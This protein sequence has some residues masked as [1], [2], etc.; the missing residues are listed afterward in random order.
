[1]NTFQSGHIRIWLIL[2]LSLS[3][4][5]QEGRGQATLTIS[6]DPT[7]S[8]WSYASGILT[9]NLTSTANVNDIIGYL[10]AGPL[11]IVGA[12]PDLSVTV[13]SAIS[14]TGTANGL[15]IG[16]DGNTGYI[17]LDGLLTLKG[18]VTLI[19]DNIDVNQNLNTQAGGAN[20]DLL[21]KASGDIV[22]KGGIS[23][24]TNGGDAIFWA[25]SDGQSS[26]GGVI[27]KSGSAV[28]TG[29]GHIWIGG[30]NSTATWQGLTVGNGA[31]VSGRLTDDGVYFPYSGLATDNWQA[32][33]IFNMATLSSAGG[34]IQVTGACNITPPVSSR[35]AG[36]I[37]YSGNSGTLIDAGL[38]TVQLIGNNNREG[39]GIITGLHPS[40]YT[41]KFIVKSSNSTSANAIMLEGNAN[42]W[43]GVDG[44]LI[45]DHTRL[46]SSATTSGGGISIIGSAGFG[47]NG[48]MVGSN[49]LCEV[50]SA[51]G[52]ITVNAGTISALGVDGTAFFNI[53]SVSG[54][55]DV[56]ASTASVDI[57]YDNNSTTG[58]IPIRTSG[59]CIIKHNS[60]PGFGPRIITTPYSFQGVSAL[61][62]GDASDPLNAAV[63]IDVPLSIA[64]PITVYGGHHV[65]VSE[66]ITSTTGADISLYALYQFG[67]P[68]SSKRKRI[69]TSGGDITIN[70]DLDANGDPGGN[71]A[72]YLNDLTLDAGAGDIKVTGAT[73]GWLATDPLPYING[74]GTFTLESGDGDFK[75]M[76]NT[77]MFQFDQDGNGMGG[78]TIGKTTN[79]SPVIHD[80]PGGITAAGP[81]KIYAGG[82]DLNTPLTATGASGT[83]DIIATAG[84]TMNVP[85]IAS[86]NK[87]IEVQN[88][89]KIMGEITN[90]TLTG[91]VDPQLI[92]GT[93][94]ITNFTVNKPLNYLS[95]MS[96]VGLIDMKTVTGVLTITSGKLGVGGSY[97]SIPGNLKLKSD[98]NGT[99]RVAAHTVAGRI[100][101]TVI[102]ERFIPATSGGTPR[103]KQWRTIGIPFQNGDLF[104]ITGIGRSTTAGSESFMSFKES[105][106]DKVNYGNS[107]ARNAGY[108]PLGVFDNQI[109]F[110][111]G[112]M[113]WIYG[114][115]NTT[116]LTGGNLPTDLT[117]SHWGL[118][119][120]SGAD[121]SITDPLI[122]NTKNGWNLVSNPY[123]SPIDWRLV[124]KSNVA[125]T[126]Y[127]WDPVAANWT[128]YNATTGVAGGN[129]SP[130]IESGSAFFIS[131]ATPGVGTMTLT[132]PQSAKV[133][134]T[135]NKHFSKAPFR[136][137]IPG[138]RV[139]PIGD[140]A[141]L[142]L[143]AS[144][145]GNPIPGEAYLDVSRTDA[146]KGWDPKYDGWMM[147]RSSGANVYFDGEKDQDFSMQFDEPL[148]TGE[149][150]YYPLTV[151]TPQAGETLIDIASEGKWPA[152]HTV[153]LIDQKA[154][155][156]ILMKGNTLKYKVPLDKLKSEGRFVLAINHVKPDSDGSMPG[157]QLKVL[158]NP[159]TG[160]TIDLLVTHPTAAAKRWKVWDMTGRE[161]GSGV[162]AADAG[163]QHRLTVPGMRNPGIYLV[164]VEMEN[165]ETSQLR[166]QR[167]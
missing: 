123:A 84:L 124:L 60:G 36:I 144:G 95:E 55:V 72:L 32:G 63:E 150:R 41:G 109:P 78:L 122:T 45:E 25:N 42:P 136:L 68:T 81:I 65:Y 73:L 125:A 165:G 19:G 97:G 44:I 75:A 67:M 66:D 111:L 28:S 94:T 7:T 155:K 56:A 76:I 1:M 128:T 22:V 160:N 112:F 114:S 77:S 115:D 153:A 5:A 148:K 138:E 131:A 70:A 116:P 37:N 85:L 147:A 11:T 159:V 108:Q 102:V 156:T 141:G 135:E 158:G 10:N 133:A 29:G 2:M 140:L 43:G 3:L 57:L 146:T 6:A 142:R 79:V 157:L 89:A 52:A 53:G 164:Q 92:E 83:I 71:G 163:I 49:S 134:T 101:G 149:Q 24:T 152:S 80:H 26:N 143:K 61:T 126:V 161:A 31:A 64:G 35:G 91:D 62:L 103:P 34:H 137:D 46:I 4:L 151:T 88:G 39:F 129:G 118:M 69:S 110:G 117:I 106:D 47:R 54:D 38:G 86:S 23:L 99:A 127:R 40:E 162:F 58:S 50:L 139:R 17:N 121:Y 90:L 20:G 107:G 74:T 145:M 9:V 15:V 12:T 48:L 104:T 21:I 51:S 96:S 98:A 166:I 105:D 30:G 14:S 33:V 130:F 18:G 119:N 113:A 87:N 59:A 154:G 100:E 167:N 8:G 27:F 132:V 13:S 120:E 82:L 16:A 93:A